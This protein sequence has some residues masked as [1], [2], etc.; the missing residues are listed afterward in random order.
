MNI[1]LAVHLDGTLDERNEI[2]FTK[3]EQQREKENEEN[4]TVF[5]INVERAK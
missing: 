5:V 2:P 1:L 4:E 3:Y